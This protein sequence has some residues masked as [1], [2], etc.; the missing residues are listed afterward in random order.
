MCHVLVGKEKESNE[1]MRIC[2]IADLSS[3]SV[4]LWKA[5]HVVAHQELER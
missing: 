5:V 1:N 4:L 3:A 2:I